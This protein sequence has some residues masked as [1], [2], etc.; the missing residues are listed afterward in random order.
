MEVITFV[1]GNVPISKIKD[2]ESDYKNLKQNEK[3][4]GMIASYL[5]QDADRKGRYIIETVWAS[6]EALDKMGNEQLEVVELFERSGVRPTIRA[7][8][9]VNNF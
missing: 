8:N 3:P 2:F 7:Y 9:M 1:E 5:I 4:E 6:Q